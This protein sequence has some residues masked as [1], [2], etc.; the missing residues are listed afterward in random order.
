MDFKYQAG[1]VGL[2]LQASLLAIAVAVYWSGS[3]SQQ[4]PL[5]L[6]LCLIVSSSILNVFVT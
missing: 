5:L 2:V 3:L 6:F 4:T 1:A